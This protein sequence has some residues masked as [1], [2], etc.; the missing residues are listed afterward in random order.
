MNSQ[1]LLRLAVG[2]AFVIVA[3]AVAIRVM[4]PNRVD[5]SGIGDAV[6]DLADRASKIRRIELETG[7]EHAIAERGPAGW[8]LAS[9]SGFP[10]NE[11]ALQGI[12]RGLIALQKSQRMTAMPAR[13]GEL[14]LAWP[15]PKGETR[16][17]R[18]YAEGSDVPAAELLI[19]R[20]AQSPTGVFIR[21][22]DDP[23]AWRC[24]GALQLGS[25]GGGWI[26]GPVSEI[27]ADALKSVECEGIRLVPTN[28][29]W[30]VEG[31]PPEPTSPDAPPGDPKSAAMRGTLPYLLSGLQPEDVRRETADDAAR[32]PAITATI[33]VD[34]GHTVVA[35]LWQEGDDVWVA[36]ALGQC[37]GPSNAT[38]DEQAPKWSGWVFKL[39]SWRSGQYKALFGT[40][41]VP[42][43]TEVP[44]LL[45][46]PAAPVTPAP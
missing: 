4:G 14:G 44:E 25:E 45:A 7:K 24:T 31:A 2:L 5:T 30:G 40:P 32:A 38:L 37:E 42:P 19:G 39:P 20:Q 8:T 9:R 41:P 16:L 13:H 23:Q 35:R 12:V 36:L 27:G 34:E 6:V 29:Q 22:V 26:A 11:S 10:A 1:R 21:M 46:P 43:M 3:V 28:G 15:D 33:R 18:I 17:V